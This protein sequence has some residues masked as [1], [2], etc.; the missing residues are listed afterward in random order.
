MRRPPCS[1]WISWIVRFEI[2]NV[3]INV[4]YRD[5]RRAPF[6]DYLPDYNLSI[7]VAAMPD[8]R[9]A[10]DLVDFILERYS[11][12][13]VEVGVGKATEVSA[14]LS[15]KL[16]LMATDLVGGQENGL[17]IVGDDIFSPRKELYK[18]ASLIYAI[19]PP[20]EL[21]LAMGRL[22][23]EIGAEVIVRPLAD[24]VAKLSGFQRSLINR[25]QA[26]FYLFTPLTEYSTS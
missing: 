18:G 19:R 9:G 11:G 3:N 20:L 16:D 1:L 6:W 17:G 12:K 21:Q 4:R 22:A 24:E 8:I 10:K 23:Q 26:R 13:V 5:Y 2:S 7:E 25:G 14:E 15:Q